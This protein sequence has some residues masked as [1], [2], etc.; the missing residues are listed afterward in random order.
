MAVEIGGIYVAFQTDAQTFEAT[1]RRAAGTVDTQSARMGKSVNATA[2]QVRG[3]DAALGGLKGDMFNA[4]AANALRTEKNIARLGNTLQ[5]IRGLAAGIGT[6]FSV[7]SLTNYADAATSI[8]NRIAAVTD[9]QKQRLAIEKEIYAA[10]NRSYAAVEGTAQLYTR[11]AIT[12]QA[13][14]ASSAQLLRV[15]EVTQKALVIGGASPQEASATITQLT[16]ALG[17]GRLQ[18]DELRSLLENAPVLVKAIA[19]EFGVTVGELKKL[20]S[21]GKLLSDRVLKGILS[22]AENIERRFSSM[23]P[24]IRQSLTVLN[25]EMTAY[26]AGV[27]SAYNISGRL[28]STIQALADN[29]TAVGN[30]AAY[31][32][33]AIAAIYA[34]RKIGAAA[35]LVTARQYV[36]GLDAPQRDAAAQARAATDAAREGFQASVG[37]Y[38]NARAMPDQDLAPRRMTSVANRAILQEEKALTALQK[39]KERLAA[40]EIAVDQATAAKKQAISNQI[41][42]MKAREGEQLAAVTH[43]TQTKL[44][45][46]GK[47]E[48]AAAVQRTRARTEMEGYARTL[49]AAQSQE[50]AAG[51]AAFE[52]GQLRAKAWSMA[53]AAGNAMVSFLGGPLGVALTAATAGWIYYE[54]MQARAA[55]RSRKAKE[56]IEGIAEALKRLKEAQSA[57]PVTLRNTVR[58]TE[59]QV[60]DIG[61]DAWGQYRNVIGL[62]Q[63]AAGKLMGYSGN[64]PAQQVSKDLIDIVAEMER[65]RLSGGDVTTQMERLADKMR[66]AANI[67]T[68]LKDKADEVD[69]LT[70]ALRPAIKAVRDLQSAI[71]DARRTAGALDAKDLADKVM[72][73]WVPEGGRLALKDRELAA[74]NERRS[75]IVSGAF[76]ARL[77]QAQRST[78]QAAIDDIASEIQRTMAGRGVALTNEEVQQQARREYDAR[79]AVTD[80]ERKEEGAKRKAEQAT[81]RAERERERRA[82]RE[83]RLKFEAEASFFSDEDRELIEELKELKTPNSVIASTMSAL[84]DGGALPDEARRV[85]G[86]LHQRAAGEEYQRLVEQYGGMEKLQPKITAYQEKLNIAVARGALTAEEAKEAYAD[87]LADFKQYEYIDTLATSFEDFGKTISDAFLDGTLSADTFA[88]ALKNLEKQI[89]NL[90]LQELV[91]D[92]LKKSI[93]GFL[94][95]AVGGGAT[96]AGGTGATGGA[97]SGFGAIIASALG[98]KTATVTNAPS[99]PA[100]DTVGGLG[101]VGEVLAAPLKN[102]AAGPASVSQ[103][104]W[105][106]FSGKGLANHQ[107]AGII[108]ALDRE[109]AFNPFAVNGNGGATGLMQAR[110]SRQSDLMSYTGGNLGDVNRQFEFM[111]KEFQ[112]TEKKAFDSLLKSTDLRGATRA[113]A[114]YE[115]PEGYTA[116][117]PAGIHDFDI[118]LTKSAEALTRHGQVASK[119]ATGVD[120]LASMTAPAGSGLVDLGAGAKDAIGGLDNLGDGLTTFGTRLASASASGGAGGLGGIFSSLFGG[121][122]G[123]QFG[124]GWSVGDINPE[125]YAGF[126]HSGGIAGYPKSSRL[127]SPQLFAAAQRYHGGGVAGLGPGEVPAILKRGEPV[128]TQEQ[129]QSIMERLRHAEGLALEAGIQRVISD[130]EAGGMSAS[131]AAAL[132]SAA[133]V[134]PQV[135]VTV[136]NQSGLP[137]ET[138]QGADGGLEVFIPAIENA[139]AARAGR[140]HGSLGK[141]VTSSA[142]GRNLRG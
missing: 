69:T 67:D 2:T 6:A 68:K 72:G 142:S 18:G 129:E 49:R 86:L 24:T 51:R 91:F 136:N 31:A 37:A 10:S 66:A 20:G 73:A 56:A 17:S 123:T 60:R 13:L 85:Q 138:R 59:G 23:T 127:V 122:F 29:L 81:E 92:P 4:L 21:E 19:D 131:G 95:D 108:G 39:T 5:I 43:A 97:V 34:G 41:V 111:W 7:S 71:E 135:N 115:R 54:Q 137:V 53:S 116:S 75:G 1:L 16:Q 42:A 65:V 52:A 25:N 61:A 22:G 87:F 105:D 107:V 83:E 30:A 84:R 114:M 125:V 74:A 76:G 35:P 50:V 46:L 80:R 32:G 38:R 14:G 120:R 3:L 121:A 132:S 15:A 96:G 141:A 44:A 78:E 134:R 98:G 11:M 99:G 133:P 119:A 103:Q 70:E 57:D 45:A 79:K 93:K 55:E 36:V 140:G 89:A 128:L 130:S 9:E 27:D 117:N 88:D 26:V 102:L 113:M 106:F 112:T 90:V 33:G 100:S 58:G 48:E 12:A 40:L 139:M 94:S 28:A 8:R 62:A 47:I 77:S 109:S 104:A 82:E 64:Q 126:Y 110:G 63:G 101:K 124:G 118:R